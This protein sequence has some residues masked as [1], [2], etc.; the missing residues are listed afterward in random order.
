MAYTKRCKRIIIFFWF[1]KLLLAIYFQLF[2]NRRVNFYFIP[3][4]RVMGLVY[5]FANL[6]F[7]N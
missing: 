5:F 6:L 1:Y 3:E 7:I 2:N 4:R